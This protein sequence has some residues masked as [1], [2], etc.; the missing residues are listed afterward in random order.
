M[1]IS[2]S[3]THRR[4]VRLLIGAVLAS[5]LDVG[6]MQ[7]QC[8]VADVR[9]G[10][11][12]TPHRM[13]LGFGNLL[14]TPDLTRGA[15][16]WFATN[17][18]AQSDGRDVEREFDERFDPDMLFAWV[19]YTRLL[20]A[21]VA[22]NPGDTS[23]VVTSPQIRGLN[24]GTILV[25]RPRKGRRLADDSRV[26]MIPQSGDP[27]MIQLDRSDMEKLLN[28]AEQAAQGS[29]YVRDSTATADD[30]S[31]G[32]VGPSLIKSKLHLHYPAALQ[33]SLVQGEVWSRFCVG[34]D[35]RADLTTFTALLSDDA[36]FER[37]V[38]RYLEDARYRPATRDGIPIRHPVSQRFLFTF[39]P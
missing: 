11:R 37:S 10:G 23:A 25:G 5:A 19:D 26:L 39:R 2:T 6:P 29:A 15:G 35:G 4:A 34:E 17:H 9:S 24:G 18:G 16:F 1:A 30:T 27:V 8:T 20:L 12:G 14:M 21:M 32:I 7:A 31:R 22:P 33:D 36:A 3:P 13:K 38:K 28:F